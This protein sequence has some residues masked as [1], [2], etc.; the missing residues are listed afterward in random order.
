MFLVLLRFVLFFLFALKILFYFSDEDFLLNKKQVQEFHQCVKQ[1]DLPP[2]S[3]QTYGS[4]KA[5]SKLSITTLVE[6]GV[7]FVAHIVGLAGQ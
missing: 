6:I 5:L 4:V 2:L 7:D 1:S 3:I